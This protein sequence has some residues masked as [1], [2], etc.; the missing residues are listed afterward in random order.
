[1][2]AIGYRRG[3]RG[4]D[5]RPFGTTL[6]AALACIAIF[7]MLGGFHMRPWA[8]LEASSK[9]APTVNMASLQRYRSGQLPMHDGSFEQEAATR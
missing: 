3:G 9:V 2:G 8:W 6:L 5:R 7:A 1:M 4:P